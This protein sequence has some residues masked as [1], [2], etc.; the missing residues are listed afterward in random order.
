MTYSLDEVLLL[1]LVAVLGGADLRGYR[2][3]RREEA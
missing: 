3:V 1:Y 2:A